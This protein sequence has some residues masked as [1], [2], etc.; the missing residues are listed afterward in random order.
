MTNS[1]EEDEDETAE[2][3]THNEK[4]REGSKTAQRIMIIYKSRN[5]SNK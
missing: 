3:T 2:R 5:N 4:K 1:N